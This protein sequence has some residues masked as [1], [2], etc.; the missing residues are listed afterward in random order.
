MLALEGVQ[1]AMDGKPVR[2][3]I[4]VP[5]EDPVNVVVL[6]LASCAVQR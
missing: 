6:T 1:R 3:V 2:K 4:V 5:A